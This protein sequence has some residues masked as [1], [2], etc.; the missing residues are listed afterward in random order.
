MNKI[1]K[2]EVQKNNKK[3]VNIYVNE[4]FAFAC[5]ME[6]V[7]RYNLAKDAEIKIEDIREVLIEE[8]YISCKNYTLR[9]LERGY[10]TEKE[11][12]KKLIEREYSQETISRVQD[13]LKEYNFIDD[14]RYTSMYVKDK[15][16]NEG[17]NKIKYK[18]MQKGVAEET[19]AKT[20]NNVNEEDEYEGALALCEKKY[21]ILI[22]RE[23]DS[24][25]IKQKIFR[26]LA[27]KGYDFDLINRIIRKVVNEEYE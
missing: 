26:F 24:R 1:T 23:T 4:N 25:L 18:L 13:F 15:I 8:E 11:I 6:L 27:S 12:E 14:R 16:K 5:D 9:I 21:R 3:R 22:K 17:R 2:V 7:Y 20:I 19:I 10:K